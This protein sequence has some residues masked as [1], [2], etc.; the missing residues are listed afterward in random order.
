MPQISVIVCCYNS[1]KRLPETLLHLSRQ[2]IAHQDWELVVVDNAS[3]DETAEVCRDQWNALGCGAPLRVLKEPK[4]GLSNARRTGLLNTRTEIVVFC[5][6]DNWLEQSYLERARNFMADHP[7]VGALGG[8]SDPVFDKGIQPPSWFPANSGAFAVGKQST[9]SGD[10]TD[11]GFLWGAGLVIRGNVVRHLLQL[12]AVQHLSGRSGKALLAGD[13]T[14][15][16]MWLILSGFRLHYKEDLYFRHHIAASRLSK[17]YLDTT[18]IG[19]AAS[20]PW[21]SAYFAYYKRRSLLE[22]ARSF[23]FCDLWLLCRNELIIASRGHR[24]RSNV[25]LISTESRN[26]P[27]HLPILGGSN[28]KAPG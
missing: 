21:L 8:R 9:V 16:C 11:R 2:S 20:K 12:G 25:R 3:K 6:D 26:R 13:D 5:D 27:W 7:S 23:H 10:V 14:E 15:I 24:V 22:R 19:F 4:P 28:Y 18:K 17:E 1:A